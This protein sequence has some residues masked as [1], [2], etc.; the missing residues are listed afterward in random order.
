MIDAEF[1]V[2]SSGEI[3][4]FH[5]SGHAEMDDYGRDVVCAFVSSAAYMA[6]NTITDIIHAE[7]DVSADDGDM[8]V[9]VAKKDAVL[10]RDILDGLKLHLLNT[11][12]QYPEFLNVN[13]TEV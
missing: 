12:E 5:L 11:Q 10:C 1:F 2:N 13:Y 6:A 8:C 4:G 7:A 3:L 9:M